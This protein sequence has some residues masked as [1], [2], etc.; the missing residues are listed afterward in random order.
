MGEGRGQEGAYFSVIP[1]CNQHIMVWILRVFRCYIWFPYFWIISNVVFVNTF[2]M[3]LSTTFTY[4]TLSNKKCG[5]KNKKPKIPPLVERVCCWG[6]GMYFGISCSLWWF[7]TPITTEKRSAMWFMRDKMCWKS[8]S[9]LE[10][11]I[12]R[13]HTLS[14]VY[15]YIIFVIIISTSMLFESLNFVDM[16]ESGVACRPLCS[17][18]GKMWFHKM[19]YMMLYIKENWL[20]TYKLLKPA[21]F[22]VF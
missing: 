7:P 22:C 1:T 9:W 16:I 17:A 21:T 3:R 2:F 18:I 10:V 20:L 5:L 19:T 12:S 4:I 8:F 13:F 11:N 14:C 6:V 15:S